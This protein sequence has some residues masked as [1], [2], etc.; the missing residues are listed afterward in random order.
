MKHFLGN[1]IDTGC[2]ML[3]NNKLWYANKCISKPRD[4]FYHKSITDT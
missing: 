4:T 2:D 3:Y 1:V